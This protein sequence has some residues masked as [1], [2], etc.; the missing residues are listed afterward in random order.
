MN[1]HFL[2]K[3]PI[4]LHNLVQNDISQNNFANIKIYTV[5]D[6]I[7]FKYKAKEYKSIL[8]QLP[9]I[10]EIQKTLDKTQY[11]KV[12]DVSNCIYVIDNEE[13][14]IDKVASNNLIN[15]I[16]T[17]NHNNQDRNEIEMQNNDKHLKKINLNNKKNTEIQN[18]SNDIKNLKINNI[19]QIK[20]NSESK[21]NSYD[22]KNIKINSNDIKNDSKSKINSIDIENIKIN[23]NDMKNIKININDT[24]NLKINNINEEIIF[25]Q[26]INNHSP[27]IL[28][29]LEKTKNIL[30]LSGIS[31]SLKYCKIRR[32]AGKP[33]QFIKSQEQ[34]QKVKE[35]IE[36]EKLASH[37]E[38]IYNL[39]EE[40]ESDISSFAAEI[41]Y[42]LNQP[43]NLLMSDEMKTKKNLL[44]ELAEKIKQKE[45][46][47]EGVGNI[48]IKKRFLENIENMKHEYEKLKKE[49]E[50][51]SR[52]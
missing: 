33:K 16:K 25:E 5:N 15:N 41:E 18:N 29:K 11:Y 4:N 48:I 39:K 14:I 27:S 1:D 50:E 24:K 44:N 47:L 52:N 26:E 40:E 35:L 43:E 38:I 9:T 23:S 3:L 49:I 30:E 17:L 19:D 8:Y 12:G 2:L 20:N 22:L 10:T 13:I 36:R 34:E 31:P 45:I 6:T 37:I 46:Q 21:N 51:C 7:I 28:N 42:N 32:F